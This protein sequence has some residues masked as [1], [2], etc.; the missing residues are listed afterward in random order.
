LITRADAEFLLSCKQDA[1]TEAEQRDLAQ[2][3]LRFLRRRLKRLEPVAATAADLR[4]QDKQ[5]AN[6]SCSRV[7]A[8]V[9]E[10]RSLLT[11]PLP[12]SPTRTGTRSSGRTSKPSPPWPRRCERHTNLVTDSITDL[13]SEPCDTVTVAFTRTQADALFGLLRQAARCSYRLLITDDL[14][15]AWCELSAAWARTNPGR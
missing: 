1:M 5:G 9:Q 3:W 11:G 4:A 2:W 10:E 7:V 13:V 12:R 6:D 14:R 8:W 15:D